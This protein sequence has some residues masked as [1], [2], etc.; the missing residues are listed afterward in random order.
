MNLS[1]RPEYALISVKGLFALERWFLFL[2]SLKFYNF[3]SDHIRPTLQI[4][5]NFKAHLFFYG[6]LHPFLI[7]KGYMLMLITGQFNKFNM[8]PKTKQAIFLGPSLKFQKML[9]QVLCGAGW[10][11]RRTHFWGRHLDTLQIILFFDFLRTTTLWIAVVYLLKS[12]F[13]LLCL[14]IFYNYR[15]RF[16]NYPPVG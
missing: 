7:L 10:Q 16:G 4:K 8:H 1:C 9:W 11:K 5:P 13:S 15:S 14:L 2:L 3:V 12:Y 6:R